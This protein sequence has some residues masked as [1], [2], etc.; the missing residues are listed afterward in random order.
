[1]AELKSELKLKVLWVG[2]QP[3]TRML[4]VLHS[5]SVFTAMP[6][7]K[8]SALY[9]TFIAFL[10]G[11][12]YYLHKGDE[13]LEGT[14]PKIILLAMRGGEMSGLLNRRQI[15]FPVVAG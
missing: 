12:E 15:L 3:G 11:V 13:E 2:A 9:N 8:K 4:T 10:R 5:Y 7:G 6:S 1:M 14:L